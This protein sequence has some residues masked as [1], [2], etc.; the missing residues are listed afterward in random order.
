MI[1]DFS[2]VMVCA[3]HTNAG[4]RAKKQ[5]PKPLRE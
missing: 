4:G 1:K 3:L 5:R 2:P